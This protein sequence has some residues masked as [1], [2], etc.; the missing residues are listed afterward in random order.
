MSFKINSSDK[1]AA[2]NQS[3]EILLSIS[4]HFDST[5]RVALHSKFIINSRAC[6]K[7]LCVGAPFTKAIDFIHD[8]LKAFSIHTISRPISLEWQVKSEFYRR[9]KLIS[10]T[11]INKDQINSTLMPPAVHDNKLSHAESY[12]F[13]CAGAL[14]VAFIATMSSEH[15]I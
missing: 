13:T 14:L 3:N 7:T 10:C 12:A 11:I 5:N 9:S 15:P 2:F 8:W 4:H 1:P 6:Y